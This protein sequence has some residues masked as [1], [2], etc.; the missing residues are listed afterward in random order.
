MFPQTM[1]E[2]PWSVAIPSARI[3]KTLDR[4]NTILWSTVAHRLNRSHTPA[5]T[6]HP[7]GWLPDSKCAHLLGQTRLRKQILKYNFF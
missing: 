6:T 2:R 5:V 3:C 1:G 7:L 4:Q